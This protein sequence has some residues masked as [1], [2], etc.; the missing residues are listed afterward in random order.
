MSSARDSAN[1][2][3]GDRAGDRADDRAAV[4]AANEELY[5]AFEAAD[6]DRMERLWVTG[7]YAASAVC[8]HPGWPALRGREAVLRSWAVIMAN[9][10]YIQFFLTDVEIELAGELAVVSCAENI[11]TSVGDEA[12][13]TSSVLAG[14]KV[15]TTNVF[16]RS[17]GQWRLWLHHGSPVL[18]P[19]GASADG[20]DDQPAGDGRDDG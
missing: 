18:A 1:E 20:G 2:R 6:L 12:D 17:E 10:A 4:R 11:L 8:V 19:S 14:G 13:D 9:T 3:A 15:V 5:A 16:R 7:P